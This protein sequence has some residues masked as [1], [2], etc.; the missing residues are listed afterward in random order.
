LSR[1]SNGASTSTR[2]HAQSCAHLAA[3][4]WRVLSAPAGTDLRTLWSSAANESF[5]LAG[6]S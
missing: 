6:R 1:G 4:G 3:S 5:A 2:N